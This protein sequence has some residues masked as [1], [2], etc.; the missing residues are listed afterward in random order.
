VVP[1]GDGSNVLHPS[2]AGTAAMATT[3]VPKA[4]WL[5]THDQHN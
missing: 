3:L 4:S 1:G 2:P 5:L